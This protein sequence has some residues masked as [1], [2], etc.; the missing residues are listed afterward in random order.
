MNIVDIKAVYPG[1]PIDS[2]GNTA[3]YLRLFYPEI[4]D[5]VLEAFNEYTDVDIIQEI[6]DLLSLDITCVTEHTGLERIV[7]GYIYGEVN[8]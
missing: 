8:A 7:H 1:T 5:Q 2:I 4:V 3:A 6:V